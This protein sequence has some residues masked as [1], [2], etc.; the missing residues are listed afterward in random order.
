MSKN[1]PSRTRQGRRDK[2]ARRRA[3]PD[4]AQKQDESGHGI[5]KTY[6]Y[7]FCRCQPCTDAATLASSRFVLRN[8]VQRE[9]TEA[10][11]ADR[12]ARGEDV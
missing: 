12:W 8:R 9:Q 11:L 5:D 1:P 10:E 2:D 4:L 3:R 6:R 7:W